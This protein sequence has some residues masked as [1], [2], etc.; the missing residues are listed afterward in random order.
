MNV[1]DTA[2]LNDRLLPTH[3]AVHHHVTFGVDPAVRVQARNDVLCDELLEACSC[4]LEQYNELKE[5]L[6]LI[7]RNHD[8]LSKSNQFH[9]RVIDDQWNELSRNDEKSAELRAHMKRR[10]FHCIKMYD[11][12]LAG[13]CDGIQETKQRIVQRN[14]EIETVT[15]NI[16]LLED[17]CRERLRAQES[18]EVFTMSEPPSEHQ[19]ISNVESLPV[20]GY[21]TVVPKSGDCTFFN[22]IPKAATVSHTGI[23]P[24]T[25]LLRFLNTATP[26]EPSDGVTAEIKAL[27]RQQSTKQWV[28]SMAADE[29]LDAARQIQQELAGPLAEYRSL[30]HESQIGTDGICETSHPDDEKHAILGKNLDHHS[31]DFTPEGDVEDALDFHGSV[32]FNPTTTE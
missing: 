10:E 14:T 16:R 11:E 3:K 31:G 21:K 25:S 29:T 32:R 4:T 15:Q 9:K 22:L 1:T 24:P 17:L 5:E 8:E 7:L 6:S 12:V 30:F 26:P 23:P 13:M 27:L 20:L 2:E 18:D 19:H 28:E